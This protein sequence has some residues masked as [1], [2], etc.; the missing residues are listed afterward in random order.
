MARLAGSGRSVRCLVAPGVDPSP[1]PSEV[2]V[3]RGDIRDRAALEPAARGVETV[4]HCVG[5]IHPKRARDFYAVNAQGTRNMLDAAIAGGARRFL[6]VSSNAAAGFQ[7]DRSV[8]MTEADASPESDYGKSKL[9]AERA[10]EATRDGG[11][12]ETVIVRPCLYYGPGLP[13]RMGR[14]FSLIEKGKMPVFGDGRALRSMTNVDELAGA[15][16]QCVDEPAA[17]GGI[18]WIADEPPYTTLSALEAMAAAIGHPLRVRHLPEL[19]ART[20]EK[21]DLLYGRLGRYSLNLH[22]VGESYRDIGCSIEKAK[23]VLSFQPRNDLVAGYREAL[24]HQTAVP[25]AG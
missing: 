15:L 1:L 7:R 5:V 12:L 19:G 10:V 8:L 16:E 13:D 25:A 9:E 4:I 22:A 18:F 23:R 21:V 20:C 11:R 14:V 17:S 24:S 6:H 2:E 3:V